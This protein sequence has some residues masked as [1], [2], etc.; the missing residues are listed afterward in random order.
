[1]KIVDANVLLHAVNRDSGQHRPAREWLGRA[2]ARPEAV[3]LAWTVVLAFLRVSTHP[4]V[5]RRPLTP[6]EAM[7]AVR[8]WLEHPTTVLVEPGVRHLSTLERLLDEAGTAG[9]LV[10]D[11]HLAALAIEHGAELVSFDTDFAR[12]QDLRWSRPSAR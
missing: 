10:S 8:S 11:A 12:F 5:F 9:N 6:G 7:R 2:L 1:M 4:S 3:G